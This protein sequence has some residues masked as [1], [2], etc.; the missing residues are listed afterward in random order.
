MS[1]HH[2]PPAGVIAFKYCTSMRVVEN[3]WNGALP[4]FSLA[5]PAGRVMTYRAPSQPATSTFGPPGTRPT[6]GSCVT[7]PKCRPCAYRK[8]SQTPTTRDRLNFATSPRWTASAKHSSRS[9]RTR[10]ST[11]KLKMT[12]QKVMLNQMRVSRQ[13]RPPSHG[14]STPSSRCSALPCYGLGVIP[15]FT[16]TR[17]KLYM[18]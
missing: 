9:R 3:T 5:P 16:Q 4:H 6:N 17:K 18:C 10:P 8:C 1:T 14:S 11:R 7:F 12:I 15:P 2:R 13:R